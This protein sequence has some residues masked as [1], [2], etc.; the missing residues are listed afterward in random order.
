MNNNIIIETDYVHTDYPGID[1]LTLHTQD[2]SVLSITHLT[3]TN[4]QREGREMGRP[5]F[6][7]HNE[8]ISGQ[9]AYLTTELYRLDINSYGLRIQFNPSKLLHSYKLLSDE[10]KLLK[11]FEQI[12]EDLLDKGME[13]KLLYFKVTR[14]DLAK[15]AIMP[16]KISVYLQA[17][18]HLTFKTT[19]SYKVNYNKQTFGSYDK[20]SA[21]TFYDKLA[22]LLGK[23]LDS[24]FMRCELK[25]QNSQSVKSKLKIRTLKEFMD[26][27]KKG[28]NELFCKELNN[29]LPATTKTFTTH[30]TLLED[31]ALKFGTE[32]RNGILKAVAVIGI[33]SILDMFGGIDKFLEPFNQHNSIKTNGRNRQY[34]LE[35]TNLHNSL[36]SPVPSVNLINEIKNEFL[37]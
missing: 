8:V 14:V 37:N 24:K 26:L 22:E 17:F 20:S 9:K 3:I 10:K 28:W 35:L 21:L 12:E 29:A 11:L 7:C 34:L 16:H 2:F 23:D 36:V 30:D 18:E 4:S 19:R 5:L 32:K 6:T 1:Y 31:L 27:K 13:V 15:Q 25:L 33:K